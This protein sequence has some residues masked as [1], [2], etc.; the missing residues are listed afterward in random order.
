MLGARAAS[1]PAR[2][3]VRGNGHLSAGFP[4]HAAI[5]FPL[6][7]VV[8]YFY[9]VAGL[10][11]PEGPLYVLWALWAILAALQITA[12]R[13]KGIVLAIPPAAL[14]LLILSAMA[15]DAYL[16]WTA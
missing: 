7:L 11:I 15:G 2:A 1:R 10:V 9:A 13:R 14:L 6:M 8:G 3:R 5:G 12:H 4:W 16:G